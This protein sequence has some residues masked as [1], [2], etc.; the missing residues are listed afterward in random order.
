MIGRLPFGATPLLACLL[1]GCSAQ[2]LEDVGEVSV[3]RPCTEMTKLFGTFSMSAKSIAWKGDKG[4]PAAILTLAL[5]FDND[6]PWPIALSN[7]GNGV[8]YAVAFSL[9]GEKGSFPPKEATGVA[10]VREPQQFKEPHRAG[11][12]A[13]PSRTKSSSANRPADKTPDVNQRIEPGKPQE[14][15]LVFQA[16]R[17]NYLL[18]IERKFDGQPVRGQPSDHIAVCKIPAG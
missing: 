10:L 2:L 7:S 6:K 17:D 11:P 1:A 14:G 8:L 15:K 4:D 12:F 13:S 18:I 5:V 9:Q 3:P 16:P